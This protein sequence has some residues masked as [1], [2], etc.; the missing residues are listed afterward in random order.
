MLV[1]AAATSL[2]LLF[3]SF[4]WLSFCPRRSVLSSI[5]PFTSIFLE[6]VAETVLSSCS[7]R[8][9]WVPRHSFPLLSDA[10]VELA[11][12]GALLVPSAVPCSLFPIYSSFF[13][14][15]RPTVSS[16]LRHAGSLDFHW[17][18]CA[19]WSRSPCLFSPSLQRTQPTVELLSLQDW[20]NRDF[21]MQ[22]LRTP[23]ISFCTLQLRTLWRLS[24]SL[25]PLV[26]VLGSCPGSGAPWSFAMP[27]SLERARVATTTNAETMA[28]TIGSRIWK[29][30]FG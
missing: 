21:F 5:F 2:P 16:I 10:A 19:R 13:S 25:R 20:Q 24:V 14:H 12:R 29:S 9:Q 1:L 6:D 17:G 15:W 27:P 28:L 23:L 4:I 3:S 11:R 8:Q 30:I 26:Q 22:R 7:I 18:T